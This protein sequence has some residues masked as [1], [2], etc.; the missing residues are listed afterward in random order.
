MMQILNNK[1]YLSLMVSGIILVLAAGIFLLFDNQE[2]EITPVIPSGSPGGF[3]FLEL[4][5][6]TRFTQEIRESLEAQLGSDVLETNTIIDLSVNYNGFLKEF[7]PDI[8][9]LNIELNDS[10]GARIEHNTIKLT[11]RYAQRKN[12]PFYYVEL[13]FSN[14]AKRPLYIKIKSKK[15]GAEII[16]IF[17]GKYGEAKKIDWAGEKGSALYWKENNDI[18]LV[19]KLKD[20]FGFSE[21]HI[22]MYFVEN[23]N[24][25]ISLEHK[26]KTELEESK[27][28]AGKTAF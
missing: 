22:T 5:A 25:L 27:K 2:E 15:E 8:H 21:Y 7:F 14:Y 26:I 18:L 10:S 28:K 13:V 6:T 24:Q 3:T 16:D 1:K 11:Y 19:S 12:T 23:I 20:R 9:R 17:N 4:G